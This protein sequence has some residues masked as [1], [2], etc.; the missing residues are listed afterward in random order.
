VLNADFGGE[1]MAATAAGPATRHPKTGERRKF[2]RPLQLDCLPLAMLDR[3][4]AERAAGRTWAEIEQSSPQW[5]EWEQAGPEA[6]ACFP[7]RRL[8][9]SSLQRWH[10]LRV[11]QVRHEQQKQSL[12][13]HAIAEQLAAHGFSGLDDAV[14]NAL[15]EAVFGLMVDGAGR[16]EVM[17]ALYQLSRLL[18]TF[19]RSQIGR[20]RLELERKR[21]DLSTQKLER[22]PRRVAGQNPEADTGDEILPE[23]SPIPMAEENEKEKEGDQSCGAN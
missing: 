21:L 14:K 4:R 19:D 20:S 11:K 1:I 17:K 8:P 6:L 3:I 15:G 18:V 2:R 7:H 12:A 10:D 16:T 22:Q 9:H 13:A 5:P 23:Q